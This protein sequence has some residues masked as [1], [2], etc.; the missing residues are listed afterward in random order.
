LDRGTGKNSSRIRIPD[1]G[2]K[3]APDP[4]SRIRNTGANCRNS[5]RDP[6]LFKRKFDVKLWQSAQKN[7]MSSIGSLRNGYSTIGR[8]QPSQRDMTRDKSEL[9]TESQQNPPDLENRFLYQWKR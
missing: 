7:K 9:E 4:G 8:S 5:F 3:K 6:E 2:D 1:P